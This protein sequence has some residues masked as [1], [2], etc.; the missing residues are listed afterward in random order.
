MTSNEKRPP[1]PNPLKRELRQEANFGCVNCGNPIIQYHHITPWSQVKEHTKENLVVLCPTCHHKANCGD[2][3]KEIVLRKKS[4]PFNKLKVF[5]KEQFFLTNYD[6]IKVKLASNIFI[7][8]P[9]ILVIKD[10]ELIRLDKDDFGNALLSAKFYNKEGLLISHIIN[11]EWYAYLNKDLWDIQYSP[12]ILK[13]HNKLRDI[14]LELDTKG[15]VINIKANLYYHCAVIK[16]DENRMTI[17]KQK[18]N[19]T[20]ENTVISD[21]NIGIHID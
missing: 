9:K 7:N 10:E 16:L 6:K 3:N 19:F 2:M 5:V 12:G 13:I 21:C 20:I 1:I 11:N 14:A 4:N 18:C 15:D 17:N 8:V